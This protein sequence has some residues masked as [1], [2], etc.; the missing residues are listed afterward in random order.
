[1][2]VELELD[3]EKL[4]TMLEW[5]ASLLFKQ[6]YIRQLQQDFSASQETYDHIRLLP[7]PDRI[8]Q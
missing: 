8:D 1:M 3:R 7:P 6:N 5:E 2:N 4:H